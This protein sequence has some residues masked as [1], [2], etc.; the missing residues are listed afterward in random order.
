MV[1][2]TD[3]NQLVIVKSCV[4]CA[5]LYIFKAVYTLDNYGTVDIATGRGVE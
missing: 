1:D 5:F 2:G 4:V 3:L